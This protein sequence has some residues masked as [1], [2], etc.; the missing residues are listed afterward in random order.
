M[1]TAAGLD[2]EHHVVAPVAVN[3]QP[4]GGVGEQQGEVGQQVEVE[5]Q[6]MREM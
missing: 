2:P 1:L 4:V 3:D 5:Q 6:D